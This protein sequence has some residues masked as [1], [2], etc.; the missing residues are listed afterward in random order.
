M[1]VRNA[2]DTNK[3]YVQHYLWTFIISLGNRTNDRTAIATAFVIVDV[4]IA[5]TAL[6]EK[7][8]A[9]TNDDRCFRR[10]G[11]RFGSRPQDFGFVLYH[12]ALFASFSMWRTGIYEA[13]EML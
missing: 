6:T 8:F 7:L 9:T 1:I 4:F 5:C 2:D 3:E 12:L 10:L 11:H 13:L